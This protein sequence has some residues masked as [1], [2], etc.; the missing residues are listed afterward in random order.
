[1]EKASHYLEACG[2]CQTSGPCIT[3]AE[4]RKAGLSNFCEPV[5][6]KYEDNELISIITKDGS[7]LPIPPGY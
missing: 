1:M 4:L 6:H 7:Y 3:G 2:G 5:M